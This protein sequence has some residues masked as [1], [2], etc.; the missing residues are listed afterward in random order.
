FTFPLPFSDFVEKTFVDGDGADRGEPF[1]LYHGYQCK[2]VNLSEARQHAIN[3]YEFAEPRALEN[4]FWTGSQGN[5][6]ALAT[7]PG[8]VILPAVVEIKAAGGALEQEIAERYG[9]VGVIH[10]PR[11]VMPYAADANLVV[12]QGDDLVTPLG[13]KWVFGGGYDGAVGPTGQVPVWG[14]Q[15]WM[16]ATGQVVGYKE[17]TVRV[18]PSD[19]NA[20][21]R[22]LNWVRILA[23]RTW[24]LTRDCV[25][26]A[27]KVLLPD[28]P[29]PTV[30]YS[31]LNAT[32]SASG[33][34]DPF[35]ME[36]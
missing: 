34:S 9:G 21:D 35:S 36:G 22:T 20:L 24:V 11:E 30:V 17:P 27:I 12:R 28:S 19:G 10:A 7:D 5:Y 2:L 32:I 23:E 15:V 8:L 3:R 33:C 18:E 6:P 13:T 26:L 14:G 25:S 16:Y 4:A 29:P 1:T 31:N